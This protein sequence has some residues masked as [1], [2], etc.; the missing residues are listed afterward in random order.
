M[1]T[2]R[3]HSGAIDVDAI[4][5]AVETHSSFLEGRLPSVSVD[6]AITASLRTT[7]IQSPKSAANHRALAI[8][9]LGQGQAAAAAA[10]AF[11]NLELAPD[12]PDAL[13]LM[14]TV[15]FV[16]G[17]NTACEAYLRA[18]LAA[19]PLRTTTWRNLAS[20]F[21]AT[22]REKQAMT[23]YRHAVSVTPGLA[24]PWRNKARTALALKRGDEA[25]RDYRRAIHL[26]PEHAEAYRNLGNAYLSMNE[27]NAAVK[28]FRHSLTI[29]P[30][31]PEVNRSLADWHFLNHNS[32]QAVRYQERLAR[33]NGG[34]LP[35]VTRLDRAMA[36][37]ESWRQNERAAIGASRELLGAVWEAG[38]RSARLAAALARLAALDGD[39]ELALAYLTLAMD[40]DHSVRR[41]CERAMLRLAE[42]DV[43][44]ATDEVVALRLTNLDEVDA[45]LCS[46]LS[47]QVSSYDVLGI[48]ET[49]WL[50]WLADLAVTHARAMRGLIARLIASGPTTP[51]LRWM[52]SYLAVLCGDVSA[53]IASMKRWIDGITT[54]DNHN[55][56]ENFHW[57]WSVARHLIEMGD[58]DSAQQ[59]CDLFLSNED[60]LN[61]AYA[62]S[63]QIIGAYSG[64]LDLW[65]E[66]LF[67][68]IDRL[69]NNMKSDDNAVDRLQR[70]ILTTSFL[71]GDDK[72]YDRLC[73]FAVDLH[74]SRL[75]PPTLEA[76]L[77]P[78]TEVIERKLRIGY[79][80]TDFLHQDLPPEQHILR[81]HN[82]ERFEIVVYFFTPR[83]LP[84]SRRLT[85]VPPLLASFDG[86]VRNM[87][88]R[89]AEEMARIVREDRIDVLVDVVGWWAT[90]VPELFVQRPA[91]LQVTWLGLGRPGKAGIIDYIIGT[92]ALFPRSFDDR[93][94]EKFIRFPGSY[95]PP[96]PLLDPIA[97]TPRHLLGIPD[98]AFVFLGYH[99]TMKITRACLALWMEILR[100]APNSVLLLP[101]GISSKEVSALLRHHDIA[102]D[103]IYLL[104]WVRTEA[105]N[106]ARIGVADLYLDSFPF[107]SAALTGFD[108]IRMGVPRITLSGDAL[109]SRFGQ[110][111]LGAL[112]LDELVCRDQGEYVDRAVALYENPKEL[113]RIRAKMAAAAVDN[114]LIE[115]EPLMRKLETVYAAI[116]DRHQ[117]GEP[118]A[119]FDVPPT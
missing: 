37:Q 23:A 32:E 94:A 13:H 39:R 116:W 117:R 85:G 99:Q 34:V 46:L 79:V 44:R 22:S 98:G 57:M 86:V 11:A 92:D 5:T 8:L 27:R 6:L 18:A 28:C 66:R 115:A 88:N 118:P 9:L 26:T 20:L 114:P 75:P 50:Q 68:H 45:W 93:Y 52:E 112:D 95:I 47:P 67:F 100:R 96:K 25:V 33:L 62:N 71:A 104:N 48:V 41:G 42:G 106:I 43:E 89:S 110:V 61:Y 108:A 29:D 76:G 2:T 80:I 35:S 103:R 36:A 70:Y 58:L 101:S 97:K 54:S 69:I 53:G 102:P 55:H 91:P 82:R 83:T 7:L 81:Y 107:N 38:C 19:D 59:V 51:I 4:L 87:T 65:L 77:R 40:N 60:L 63:F 78:T 17:W 119:G 49:V 56:I 15:T 84:Q 16:L 90:E 113:Q 64:Q 31:L 105:E 21:Y 111:L 30:A 109:Y 14:G 72:Y 74:K 10:A 24:E 73:A 3:V 1:E 12:D